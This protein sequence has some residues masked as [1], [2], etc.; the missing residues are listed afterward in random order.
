M[1]NILVFYAEGIVEVKPGETRSRRSHKNREPKMTVCKILSGSRL[2]QM[3]ELSHLFFAGDW[4]QAVNLYEINNSLRILRSLFR[5]K[6]CYHPVRFLDSKPILTDELKSLSCLQITNCRIRKIPRSLVSLSFVVMPNPQ[7]V[8]LSKRS[9]KFVIY[10]FK[11]QI[12]VDF[13]YTWVQP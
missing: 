4:N 11:R 5:K 8:Q 10:T 2:E 9:A 1:I 7:V 3:I 12:L 6:F 13:Y